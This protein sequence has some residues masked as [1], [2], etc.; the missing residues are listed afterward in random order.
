M[1][2]ERRE[3]YIPPNPNYTYNGA[4]YRSPADPNGP[5]LIRKDRDAP[6]RIEFPDGIVEGGRANSV[7]STGR[8]RR[9]ES[10]RERDEA[11]RTN[12][13]IAFDVAMAE[14]A[15]LYYT[16][17]SAGS[18]SRSVT[19][20][21]ALAQ[22]RAAIQ[23]SL[24]AS[25]KHIADSFVRM[26]KELDRQ[27]QAGVGEI[28]KAR[29]A[30]MAELTQV[31]GDF[32]A[33][34]ADVDAKI[35]KSVTTTSE[36]IGRDAEA[37]MRDLKAQGASTSGAKDTVL[38]GKAQAANQGQIQGDLVQ[39]LNEINDNYLDRN[40]QTTSNIQQGATTDLE[41]SFANLVAG[42]TQDRAD[43]EFEVSESARQALLQLALNPPKRTVGGGGG[44]PSG[45]VFSQKDSALHQMLVRGGMHPDQATLA[46]MSGNS[47]QAADSLLF[48]KA[49]E[50][51][52]SDEIIAQ[53]VGQDPA[54]AQAAIDATTAR[55][56]KN[57]L[58]DEQ[59]AIL[60]DQP[61]RRRR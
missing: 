53:Y 27:R 19:D 22:Q 43:K 40:K 50:G 35:A 16:P 31:Q 11:I 56:A 28:Q 55:I 51:R 20:G 21:A 52:S 39:R 36:Q 3:H 33:R 4:P 24:D 25:L 23:Q 2:R 37:I 1:A 58:S 61:S 15:G 38:A 29:D 30:V 32:R 60:M 49:A 48:P 5:P 10:Y 42:I 45:G 57:G 41:G 17:G 18:P 9:E 6:V 26:Q 8:D 14:A 12:E 54:T 7:Y 34:A 46:V 44:R 47:N 59:A 13:S